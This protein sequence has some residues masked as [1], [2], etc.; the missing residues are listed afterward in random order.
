MLG[1]ARAALVAALAAAAAPPLFPTNWTS[2]VYMY[3]IIGGAA[4]LLS[5][6][7]VS[8]SF[9]SNRRAFAATSARVRSEVSLASACAASSA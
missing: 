7:R 2:N 3:G 1:V 8:S 6:A 9:S 5:D 4:H